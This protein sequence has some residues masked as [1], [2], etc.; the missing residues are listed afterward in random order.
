MDKVALHRISRAKAATANGFE[1]LSLYAAAVVAG[2]VSGM[3]V[4]RL[5]Q[6]SILYIMSRVVYNYVYVSLQ[7]NAK[8]AGLR[9]LVWGVGIAVIMGLF[10]GAGKAL[11]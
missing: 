1:T 7:D 5:N 6:L 4:A 2:N 11:N 3:S 10:I 9:P 8:L